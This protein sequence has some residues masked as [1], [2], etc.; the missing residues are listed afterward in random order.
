SGATAPSAAA[1]RENKPAPRGYDQ[2][3][4]MIG[5]PDMIIERIIESQ[6]ACYFSEMTLMP[7]FGTMPYEEAARSVEL[8]AREVLP[9]VHGMEAPLHPTALPEA[10]TSEA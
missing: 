6:K 7:Q 4:L 9:V 2:S 8:F 5:T 3:N 1:A 10:E